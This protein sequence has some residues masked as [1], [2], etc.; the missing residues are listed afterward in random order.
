M[1]TDLKN[2]IVLVTGGQTGIGRAIA[3]TALSRGAVVVAASRR[4]P[5]LSKTTPATPDRLNFARLD[6]TEPESVLAL[7]EW[8]DRHFGTL[9]ALVNNAGMGVFKPVDE[10]EIDEWRAVFDTNVTGAFLCTKQAYKRM[11]DNGGGRIV[12][13]GSVADYTA[14]PGNA[15]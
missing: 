6:V 7:F 14:L 9:D 1:I 10:I 12:F 11:K 8:M 3:D 5:E 15:V 13:I 2:K 4:G